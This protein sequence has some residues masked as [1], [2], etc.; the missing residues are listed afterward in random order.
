M[1]KAVNGAHAVPSKV[2]LASGESGGTR[3]VPI[4]V[5]KVVSKF[6]KHDSQTCMT[7][8][9]GSA[10]ENS[11]LTTIGRYLRRRHSRVTSDAPAGARDTDYLCDSQVG[12]PYQS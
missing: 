7:G 5:K 9:Y 1:V 3:H 12:R 11:Q 2:S 8:G 4:D 10:L 6:A